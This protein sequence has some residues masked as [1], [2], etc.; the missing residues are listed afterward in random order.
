MS[1]PTICTIIAKNYLAAARCL[2]ES[3]LTHHPD[4]RVF[5]LV[6]D[7]PDGYFDPAQEQFSTVV[8]AD[9]NIKEFGAM[10]YRYNV[11]ELSTAVKP[12]FLEYL[13]D[14]Y[15][16]NS[17]CY[18]DP[19]IYF[20]A[21]ITEIWERLT[22]Y[23]IVLTPHLLD[24]LD[25]TYKP[26]ELTIL[27]S[28]CFNLGFIGL[29]QH[30]DLKRMLHW[31]QQK[32]IRHCV[33][34]FDTGLFV[35]QHWIDLAPGF[36]ESFYVH[37]DPGCNI[38]YWNLHNRHLTAE[39]GTY[40]VNGSPLKFFHYSGYNP[41]RPDIISK[42][43]NR[44]SFET[45]PE[46][47]PL[48]KA[49]ADRM[50]AHGHTTSQ[51][52]PYTYDF[53]Q[54]VGVSVPYIAR[55]LW[56]EW[57]TTHPLPDNLT[58]DVYRT[59]MTQFQAWLNTPIDNQKPVIT[60]LALA[61]YQQRPD[62]QQMFSNVL[63][64]NRHD[65]VQWFVKWA[66]RDHPSLTDLY[67]DPMRT[68][69]SLGKATDLKAQFYIQTT[70]FLNRIGVG[71]WLEH[72]LGP[73]VIEPVRRL[74]GASRGQTGH[75]SYDENTPPVFGINVVGH[76]TD[77]TGVGEV[78]RAS[79][80]ALDKLGVP[81]AYTLVATARNIARKH[82]ESTLHFPTGNPYQFNWLHVNADH[83]DVV[84]KELGEDFFKHKYTIGYWAWE[85]DRFPKK[86]LDRFKPFQEIWVGSSFVQRTLAAASPIP[87]LTMGAPIS[88]RPDPHLSRAQLGLPDDKFVFLFVFDMLS[89][90]ERKNPYAVIEAYRQAFGKQPANT[91]LV[92]KVTRLDHFPE[93]AQQL[94][95]AVESVSGLLMDRYLDR[96]ELTGLFHAADAYVSLHRSEGFGL[97][98]AE[99]MS[100]GKPTIATNYSGPADF[101]TP[102]NSY[103]I[104]YELVELTENHGPYQQGN[105]WA[106]PNIAQAADAMQHIVAHPE[107]A[108][109]RGAKAAS[110]INQWYSPDTIARKIAQRLQ[111][112]MH[113]Q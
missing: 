69:E 87:I 42:H 37:R 94:R 36:F 30:P 28:G 75:S 29:S 112:I 85:L 55:N 63:I 70:N 26:N 68:A 108:A 77:E 24:F 32:L 110:N 56:Q 62:L 19:D 71:P 6:I 1:Q 66:Q 40:Y 59:Y 76:L 12:F 25:D 7:E 79:M 58:P 100:L 73:R 46:L 50:H 3:F 89:Y 15:P 74:F 90:I 45:R 97:T 18:I 92:I 80:K 39:N 72:T 38:A 81:I 98:M 88:P 65:F 17:L 21:P 4:G 96:D 101:L 11:L 86:W 52:W 82:D 10:V 107:E 105:V 61:L 27:Q 20:Y 103:P 16:C 44:I 33:V 49:Y 78:A 23:G 9:I 95:T 104:D 22:T 31:W 2:T 60:K 41:S 53:H 109:C 113:H 84:Y 35:D 48:F 111:A 67:I 51:K 54:E 64:K 99:A 106:N 5:V 14:T 91:Q 13:F 83:T 93:Q 8:P 102:T 34:D 43:Q 47:V 57:E